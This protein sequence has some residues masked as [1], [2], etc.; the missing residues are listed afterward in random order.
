MQ[1]SQLI[2]LDQLKRV[3]I[4]N[5]LAAIPGIEIDA[6]AWGLTGFGIARQIGLGEPA[7]GYKRTPHHRIEDQ[8]S[9]GRSLELLSRFC[10]RKRQNQL[11]F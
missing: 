9:I 2:H 10:R 5:G 7:S 8:T 6:I 4:F 1:L 3:D 11:S